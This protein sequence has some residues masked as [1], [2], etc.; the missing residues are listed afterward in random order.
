MKHRPTKQSGPEH[1]QNTGEV[2]S[3][4]AG[5]GSLIVT[6]QLGFRTLAPV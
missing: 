4:G 6:G 1:S 5:Q 2:F 3:V